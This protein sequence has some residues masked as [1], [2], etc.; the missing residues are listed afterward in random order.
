MY[1]LDHLYALAGSPRFRNV[2]SLGCGTGRLERAIAKAGIAAEIDAI[3]GSGVSVDIAR[4]K[5]LEEGISTIRY[6]VADLNDVRLPRGVYDAVVFHQSLHHVSSVEKLLERVLASLRPGGLLFLDEW[7]GPSRFEWNERMLAQASALF[8]A[9][10]AQWRKWSELR[11]PVETND[12]SEAV[13]SSAILPA[14]H[15]LFEVQV[16]RPYGGNLVA[17]I[18]PQLERSRIPPRE[19][20]E[21]LSRWLAL[22]D[23]ELK[24]DPRTSYYTAIL[25]TPSRGAARVLG[26]AS[27]LMVRARLALRYRVLPALRFGGPS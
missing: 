13:R 3:D 6:Q 19:L 18:L 25:A 9:V 1:P 22:E 7:V 16:E 4:A 20:D 10:P 14:V 26:R 8:A 27:S 5:A 15:R 17:V 21:M 23:A 11:A 24:R 12:P 2:L